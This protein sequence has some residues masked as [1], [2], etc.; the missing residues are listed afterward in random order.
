M[1]GWIS[2]AQQCYAF[3]G[4]CSKSGSKTMVRYSQRSLFEARTL[5]RLRIQYFWR[6]SL[7]HAARTGAS[8]L[9]STE[10]CPAC[11]VSILAVARDASGE[12]H[13]AYCDRVVCG[14]W[15]NARPVLTVA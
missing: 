15:R 7:E 5:N 4:L 12:T 14:Y 2:C 9:A 10:R 13:V 1:A 6:L 8:G 11:G 3:A